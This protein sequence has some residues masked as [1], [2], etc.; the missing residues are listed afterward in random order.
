ML[1]SLI[2]FILGI[3]VGSFLNSVIYRLDDLESII[4]S[5]SHCPKC[6]KKLSWYELIPLASFVVQ[7]GRCRSCG[8]KIS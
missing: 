6:Q 7:F 8:E 2:I 4:K 5:R 3:I 1:Y